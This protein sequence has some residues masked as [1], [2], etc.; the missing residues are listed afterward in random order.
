MNSINSKAEVVIYTDGSCLGN[1]GPGGYAAILRW[2]KEMKELSGCEA[3]TTNNR[4]EMMAVITALSYLADPSKVTIYTDS[5]YLKKGLEEWL[6]KWQKNNWRTSENKPVKNKDL[7]QELVKLC[8]K[9]KVSWQWIRGHGDDPLNNRC[10]RLA[11]DA[12]KHCLE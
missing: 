7:W 11:K 1:P 10:D 2:D 4:M 6:P 12:I 3:F 9:H 5:L 8:N